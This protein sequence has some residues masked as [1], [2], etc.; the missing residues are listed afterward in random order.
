MLGSNIDELLSMFN[1]YFHTNTVRRNFIFSTTSEMILNDLLSVNYNYA[2]L[3]TEDW[4]NITNIP[5]QAEKINLRYQ[6]T[7]EPKGLIVFLAGH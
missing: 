5:S 7:L 3:T 2:I 4:N 6:V 1:F